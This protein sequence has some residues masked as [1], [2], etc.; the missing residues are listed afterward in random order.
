MTK[1]YEVNSHKWVKLLEDAPGPP[2]HRSFT[3][4]EEFYFHKV[5]GMY[6]FC[7]DVEGNIA[8]IPAW[9]LVEVLDK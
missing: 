2:Y 8:H 4:G 6:S 5:D 3:K 7:K 1:L 9:T